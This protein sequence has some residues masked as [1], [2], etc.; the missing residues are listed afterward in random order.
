MYLLFLFMKPLRWELYQNN[1]R[2]Y[3]YASHYLSE[4]HGL[5]CFQKAYFVG[6]HTGNC[7]KPHF[8]RQKIA[9]SLPNVITTNAE[10]VLD[11]IYHDF[12]LK[13]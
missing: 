6:Y 1:C 8:F 7:C 10:V 3:N 4:G 2:E 5:I 11:E 9:F 13:K 12:S